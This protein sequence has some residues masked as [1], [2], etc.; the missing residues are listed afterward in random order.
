MESANTAFAAPRRDKLAKL[1]PNPKARLREQV[2]EVML[3]HH[4]SLRTVEGRFC[5]GN[6]PLWFVFF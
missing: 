3:F 6:A 2:R 1:I 4:Y 5:I